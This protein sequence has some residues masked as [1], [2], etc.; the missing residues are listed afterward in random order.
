MKVLTTNGYKQIEDAV[1]N[2]DLIAYDTITGGLIINH[3][4]SKQKWQE[5]NFENTASVLYTEW[6][7]DNEITKT[8]ILLIDY[9]W[10]FYKINNTWTLYCQE[11]IWANDTVLHAFEL[12]VGD[13]IYDE[14]NKEVLIKTIE[15]T[16]SKE[17]W[18]VKITGDHSYIADGLM[19]HNLT[20]YWVGGGSTSAFNA[21]SPTNWAAS[22]GGPNNF[23][24]PVAAD[25]IIYD[26]NSL[27][28]CDIDGNYTV[29]SIDFKIGYPGTWNLSGIATF[30]VNGDFKCNPDTN[31]ISAINWQYSSNQL[32]FGG[33]GVNASNGKVIPFPCAL[34]SG[35]NRTISGSDFVIIPTNSGSQ[36][37]LSYAT[38]GTTGGT[39]N[40]I[41]NEKLMVCGLT[42]NE[43]SPS[44]TG[45]ADLYLIGGTVT[46]S[47]FTGGPIGLNVY[48]SSSISNVPVIPT[49][50]CIG[51]GGSLTYLSGPISSSN[52]TLIFGSGSAI[53]NSTN[54]TWSNIQAQNLAV[55]FLSSSLTAVSMSLSFAAT[56]AGTVIF[57][58]S[59]GFT[60]DDFVYSNRNTTVAGR[61]LTLQS[62]N[63][64]RVKKS[65]K[66]SGNGATGGTAQGSATLSGSVSSPRA[67]FI[68][69]HG[70]TCF[71]NGAILN[72]DAS[73]G[74][75]INTF[76]GAI[77]NNV[78]VRSFTDLPTAGYSGI[79]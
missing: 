15:E 12:K 28:N 69:D 2:D 30:T 54:L 55:I 41:S 24:V 7:G 57:T 73:G 34:S 61:R 47:G 14:E 46:T 19:K 67:I 50:I 26:S 48:I 8:D 66:L 49:R 11:S 32:R 56:N 17:W 51:A 36:S 21:T 44:I 23:S 75:T 33:A 4:V 42:A 78:N 43:A 59:N 6:N 45:S 18:R 27:G 71:S 20:R 5:Y 77:T 37:G 65:F 39:L 63:T 29:N 72:I 25:D 1:S 16:T 31:L 22:S 79:E 40:K 70:A 52:A 35:C 74:R 60:V 10:Q 53:Y 38:F 68:L 13:I 76:S 58:G 3:L 9:P 64:Y 62:G